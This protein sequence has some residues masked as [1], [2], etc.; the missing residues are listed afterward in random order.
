MFIMRIMTIILLIKYS[1][2][3]IL[4]ILIRVK[5]MN[6]ITSINYNKI[7]KIKNDLFIK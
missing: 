6:S 1:I 3:K 5:D 7:D 4:V 2:K